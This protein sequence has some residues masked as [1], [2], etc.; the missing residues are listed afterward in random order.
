MSLPDCI[1]EKGDMGNWSKGGH[2]NPRNATCLHDSWN[3]TESD[4]TKSHEKCHCGTKTATAA[5]EPYTGLW[6]Q[7]WPGMLPRSKRTETMVFKLGAKGRI[8]SRKSL[9]NDAKR[10]LELRGGRYQGP[11]YGG[12]GSS[13]FWYVWCLREA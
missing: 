5:R 7:N 4:G 10:V 8:P 11:V 9:G 3:L 12:G 2:T 1:A 13:Y 6:N